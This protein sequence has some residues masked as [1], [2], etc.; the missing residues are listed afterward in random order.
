MA[1]NALT[2]RVALNWRGAIDTDAKGTLDLKLQGAA[3]FVDAAR[4]YSLAHGI[5]Q[6]NTRQRLEAAGP[7]MALPGNKYG[8]WV[9]GF[10][11]LQ[12]LRLR[13]QLEGGAALEQPNRL[14]V[15][16]LNDIDRRILRETFRT[17]RHLQLR[18]QLDYQR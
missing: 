3:I 5:Q 11:F 18:L 17:A 6:T 9:S 16:S 1:L 4:I 7:L 2:R 13:I 15:D 14:S 12:M 10:E 8:A